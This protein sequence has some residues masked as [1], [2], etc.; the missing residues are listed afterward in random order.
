MKSLSV[1]VVLCFAINLSFSQV[2]RR[3][4]LQVYSEGLQCKCC[5]INSYLC[6]HHCC[7]LT[8]KCRHGRRPWCEGPGYSDE[9]PGDRTQAIDKERADYDECDNDQ[10]KSYQYLHSRRLTA[11]HVSHSGGL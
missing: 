1:L 7:P 9:N 5:N 8:H 2:F 4:E 3:C 10:A 6:S 11:F